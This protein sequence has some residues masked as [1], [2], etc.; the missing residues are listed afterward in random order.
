MFY[1]NL[2]FRSFIIFLL[3][4]IAFHY[5]GSE[6][7]KLLL[8]IFEIIFVFISLNYAIQKVSNVTKKFTYL[9]VFLISIS[10][11]FYIN[12]HNKIDDVFKIFGGIV[13]YIATYYLYN[14]E[15]EIS[16]R[17]QIIVAIIT[18]LPLFVL[19]IDKYI[20]FQESTKSMSIFTN[21]NNYMLYSICCVWLMMIYNFSIKMIIVFLVICVSITSTLGALL[22]LLVAIIYY[23]RHKKFNVR[24][25]FIS[26]FLLLTLI[27]FLIFSD[28][29]IFEK[30]RSSGNVFLALTNS[31][32]VGNLS[33]VSFDD[34]LA[35]SDSDDGSD[36]SFLFRIK[37]WTEIIEY[38]FDQ[39]FFY[40][41]FGSGFGSV[42]KINSFG[43][44]AHNDYLTWLV[45]L[46]ISGFLL[47]VYGV[48]SSFSK[49]SKTYFIIPYLTILIY[50]FTENLFYN[51]FAVML[52]SFC[53]AATEK[54]LKSKTI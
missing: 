50:F 16:R 25:V 29:Y 13:I 46:G 17:T 43:L 39:D 48:W 1:R 52:F 51:F 12:E 9:I 37:I 26:I 6:S 45:D 53:L 54:K 11:T 27:Y 35:V 33:N 42:P 20:G 7:L 8:Y 31:N 32:N 3:I 19:G 49:L 18:I 21:S 41:V 47:I 34:A 38:L 22:S 30:L 40:L 10:I 24:Y 28:L 44:V 23:Y 14:F 15:L 5:S 4:Q 2:F 36:L